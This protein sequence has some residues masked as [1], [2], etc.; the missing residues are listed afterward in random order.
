MKKLNEDYTAGKLKGI[1]IFC[2]NRVYKTRIPSSLHKVQYMFEF[3]NGH[4]A[5]VVEFN[6][7]KF[8]GGCQYEMLANIPGVGGNDVDRGDEHDMHKLLCELEEM[9]VVK[10]IDN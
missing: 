9:A 8:S 6:D 10:S 4:G 1:P 7:R 5:S 2:V 3:G